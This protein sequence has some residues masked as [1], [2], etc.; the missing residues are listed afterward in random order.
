MGD[1][2]RIDRFFKD[3]IPRNMEI[4]ENLRGLRGEHRAACTSAMANLS[5]MVTH[6][7][8]CACMPEMTDALAQIGA[9]FM[10]S[11]HKEFGW[12]LA[13]MEADI[14]MLRAAR[15]NYDPTKN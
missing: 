9:Q 5:M 12:P 11:F 2:E 14:D 6:A 3:A 1:E 10:S 15:M 7:G 4:M 8:A 13:E